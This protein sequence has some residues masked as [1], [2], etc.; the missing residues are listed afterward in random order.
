MEEREVE[1]LVSDNIKEPRLVHQSVH[2]G[3]PRPL[4]LEC[5]EHSVPNT[6][7]APVVGVQTVPGAAAV[8]MRLRRFS[9]QSDHLLAPW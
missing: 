4:L 3:F 2:D 5:P 9:V 6:E 7:P 1:D 8:V